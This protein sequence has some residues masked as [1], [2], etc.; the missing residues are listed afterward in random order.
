MCDCERERC[1]G[2]R[3]LQRCPSLFGGGGGQSKRTRS[4][5]SYTVSAMHMSR[6]STTRET[7]RAQDVEEEQTIEVCVEEYCTNT[8]ECSDWNQA[9][10]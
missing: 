10:V 9:R 3:E 8:V 5:S 4:L 7:C 2:W 1:R 6:V